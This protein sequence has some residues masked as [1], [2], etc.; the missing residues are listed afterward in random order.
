MGA[1]DPSAS[2][3]DVSAAFGDNSSSL[4]RDK[5]N[6]NSGATA[7]AEHEGVRQLSNEKSNLHVS[8]NV[9]AHSNSQ[10]L[11]A[12]NNGLADLDGE[13]TPPSKRKKVSHSSASTADIVALVIQ[14]LIKSGSILTSNSHFNAHQLDNQDEADGASVGTSDSKGSGR[15]NGNNRFNPIDV[16]VGHNR[17]VITLLKMFVKL[18][19]TEKNVILAWTKQFERN[20][21]TL[22]GWKRIVINGDFTVIGGN[23]PSEV[24]LHYKGGVVS[25]EELQ[26]WVNA[27][28]IVD[29]TIRDVLQQLLANCKATADW[30]VSLQD[31]TSH[32]IYSE[33]KMRFLNL[34]SDETNKE[35]VALTQLRQGSSTVLQFVDAINAK[36]T[37]IQSGDDKFTKELASQAKWTTF[38]NGV[39][40]ELAYYVIKEKSFEE[41]FKL[42]KEYEEHP[43]I[44]KARNSSSAASAGTEVNFVNWKEKK[45]SKC[46]KKGH[47][48]EQHRDNYVSRGKQSAISTQE[49][50]EESKENR[51]TSAICFN[52]GNKGHIKPNCYAKK[53]VDGFT[54]KNPFVLKEQPSRKR[55]RDEGNNVKIEQVDGSCAEVSVNTLTTQHVGTILDGGA[56]EHCFKSL[57]LIDGGKVDKDRQINGAIDGKPLVN[58]TVGSA[59]VNINGARL[60]L[61]TVIVHDGLRKNLISTQKLIKDNGLDQI[62]EKDGYSEILKNGRVISTV[63]VINSLLQVNPTKTMANTVE[64]VSMMHSKLAH[65]NCK[66]LHGAF[67][68]GYV[69]AKGGKNVFNKL[70]QNCDCED[71]KRAKSTLSSLNKAGGNKYES[72]KPRE[73]MHWDIVGPIKPESFG[74][75]KYALN[76]IDAATRFKISIPIKTKDQAAAELIKLNDVYKN[77]FGAG[78][79]QFYSDNGTEFMGEWKTY[80]QA[81]GI[82]RLQ[83]PPRRPGL[84]GLIERAN[85]T[86]MEAARAS[87]IQSGAPSQLWTHAVKY[88]TNIINSINSSPVGEGSSSQVFNGKKTQLNAD[89]CHVWGS[90]AFMHIPKA[91]VKEKFDA[92]SVA[93]IYIGCDGN[94]SVVMDPVTRQV[95]KSESVNVSDGQF[96]LIRELKAALMETEDTEHDSLL[97]EFVRGLEIEQQQIEE[98]IRVSLDT[99][100]RQPEIR[101]EEKI[102]KKKKVTAAD[103][104]ARHEQEHE[105]RL[106]IINDSSRRYPGRLNRQKP[107]REGFY[108]PTTMTNCVFTS[109]IEDDKHVQIGEDE[110]N[111]HEYLVHSVESD[112]IANSKACEESI[113]MDTEEAEARIF[114]KGQIIMSSQRCTGNNCK[115]TQCGAKTTN[116][117][118]CWNHLRKY[119]NLRIKKSLVP[120]AGRGLFTERD[121]REGEWVTKYTGDLM[122]HDDVNKESRYI[123]QLTNDVS[124]DAARTNCDSGRMVNDPRGT[125]RQPN[126][127]FVYD[128]RTKRASIRTTCR[129]KK[130]EELLVAYGNEYWGWIRQ[131]WRDTGVQTARKR[132]SKQVVAS[133]IDITTPDP[134]NVQKALNDPVEGPLWQISYDSEIKAHVDNRTFDPE[135]LDVLPDGHKAIGLKFLFKRKRTAKHEILRKTR[136]VAQGCQ[137]IEDGLDE[138]TTYAPVLSFKV[139]RV[140]LALAAVMDLELRQLDVKTAFLLADIGEE[141]YCKAPPG[142]PGTTKGQFLRVIKA[143][144]GL[145][146]APKAWNNKVK[147]KFIELGFKPCM[148]D[149]CLFTKQTVNGL[150][151]IAV[152][153]DDILCLS[154]KADKVELEG[155]I[156]SLK[157]AW[158]IND[159]GDAAKVLGMEIIRDRTNKT[160]L[161]KQ[162]A[163]IDKLL[164][165]YGME[166]CRPVDTPAVIDRGD[167]N[168]L[169][170]SEMDMDTTITDSDVGQLIVTNYG[171]YVGALLY[172][173]I[174]SHPEIQHA[175]MM[176]SKKL[177]SAEQ[178]DLVKVKRVLRYL[179]GVKHLGLYYYRGA[180]EGLPRLTA[181][182]DSDWAGDVGN[183]RSTSGNALLI[184]NCVVSWMAK[185]QPIVAQSSTEAEYIAAN[186]AGREI[187]WLR[188]L[189]DELGYTQL[190]PTELL[191][192]NQTAMLMVK[193]DGQYN[194]RKHI[195]VKY[196]WIR[197]QVTNKSI[198]VQWVDTH[199][200][201]ADIFTKSL[202]STQ[203]NY[204]SGMVTGVNS[205]T[206]IGVPRVVGLN[207]E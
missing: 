54:P 20:I 21:E 18:T 148:A 8:S 39:N 171:K 53:P 44:A 86:I 22:A 59:W 61:K 47:T 30:F 29:T 187:V 40:K 136:M 78:I 97:I 91:L 25:D 88:V 181:F 173:A 153:V 111:L 95:Y 7:T 128:R 183:R 199:N 168:P 104:V 60:F 64:I 197:E 23:I 165:M 50:K 26:R 140:L 11:E 74:G 71:C 175:V 204:I 113:E 85:R 176:L 65:I 135:P 114:K 15:N 189:L 150:I 141:V 109:F 157:L 94:K 33:F 79:K 58:P 125:G 142:F 3:E 55:K 201:L 185:Q 68:K 155:V 138:E 84:N 96:L 34:N 134:T 202:E 177:Q 6:P 180:D 154:S 100:I 119:N 103:L 118:Y 46:N 152:F 146:R 35:K 149:E 107:A 188:L 27:E 43:S 14:Q 203:F 56:T 5:D 57:D 69:T 174:T 178:S 102:N 1:G 200:Q 108:D 198:D 192:D 161:V 193:G 122:A 116:G 83:S 130:G 81:N 158:P 120:G 48:T 207:V 112:R 184:G 206:T 63:K 170:E 195:A 167:S 151:I 75:N 205:M 166:D 72:F 126:C 73:Q 32:K 194:K 106:K 89:Y 51:Q 164:K 92:K 98:A 16:F 31:E 121:L 87:M 179:K 115:G 52:C 186:E 139:L 99:Q 93:V 36:I 144:Y 169:V 82:V 12:K 13:V 45:C 191:L 131:H 101:E 10:L 162:E 42:C 156:N 123:L 143:I 49:R 4:N 129:V 76:G 62:V 133:N 19:G 24:K 38:R 172:I 90:D 145:R 132:V 124:I 117:Q 196:F 127:K 66:Y 80:C 160:L 28:R 9:N 2:M 190:D 70:K 110:L 163:Y 17:G 147:A 159:L 37:L 77:Q 41:A 137:Q 105:A 67:V 182:S